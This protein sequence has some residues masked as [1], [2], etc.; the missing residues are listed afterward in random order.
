MT[1][2]VGCVSGG[3]P[4]GVGGVSGAVQVVDSPLLKQQID[5]QRLAIKQLKSENY[6]LKVSLILHHR[7]NTL[8]CFHFMTSDLRSQAEK[9]RAQLSSL[10][11][12]QVPNMTG[13]MGEGAAS[14][15]LYRRT[16][17]LLGNLLKMSAGLRVVDIS[18]KSTGQRTCKTNNARNCNATSRI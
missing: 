1:T 16:D 15:S 14:G 12:L 10:P 5:V 11:P 6:R 8:V 17:L 3:V 7:M 4:A 9:M 13:V 18:G 2:L